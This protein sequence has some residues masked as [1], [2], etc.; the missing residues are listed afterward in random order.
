VAS[1]SLAKTLQIS[2][3]PHSRVIYHPWITKPRRSCER[4]DAIQVS[5]AMPYGRAPAFSLAFM[6]V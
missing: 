1:L 4:S 5:E 6:M 2:L 3:K